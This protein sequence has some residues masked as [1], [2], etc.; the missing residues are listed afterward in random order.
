[1]LLMRV[2]LVIGTIIDFLDTRSWIQFSYTCKAVNEFKFIQ[3]H[4]MHKQRT[5]GHCH[6]ANRVTLDDLLKWLTMS[7]G[8]LFNVD[9]SCPGSLDLRFFPLLGSSI[10]TLNLSNYKC[11]LGH[12]IF[13][14]LTDI[15][16]LNID[17]C[18]AISG[19][20]LHLLTNIQSLHMSECTSITNEALQKLTTLRTL[21]IPYCTQITNKA[22]QNLQQLRVLDIRWC[23]LVTGAL[24]QYL[25]N[26]DTLQI[27]GDSIRSSDF[28]YLTGLRHV[29]LCNCPQVTN[30][31]FRG[32]KHLES[33]FVTHC[34]N[35][36]SAAFTHLPGNCTNSACYMGLVFTRRRR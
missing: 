22:L 33:A 13:V 20:N 10:H 23:S 25:P 11:L 27:A 28:K 30:V 8:T 15:S 24:F 4:M 32:L 3:L 16:V 36:T 12:D 6:F 7:K 18:T 29:T 34:D 19:D 5:R 31:A 9:F 17:G 1:M 35:I 21:C 14:H 2:Q 26:L